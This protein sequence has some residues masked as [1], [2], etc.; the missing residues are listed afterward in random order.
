[1]AIETEFTL[2]LRRFDR[3]LESAEQRVNRSANNMNRSL[4][5]VGNSGSSG[6][7]Q[8]NAVA[9]RFDAIGDSADKAVTAIDSV[10]GAMGAASTGVTGLAGDLVNLIKNPASLW[11]A[12]VGMAVAAA[13]K[14]IDKFTLSASEMQERLKHFAEE[15]K[16][17]RREVEAAH[18]QERDYIDRL[19]ELSEAE[20][21]SQ[22]SKREAA[23]LIDQLN[24]KYGN[25]GITINSVTGEIEGLAD[26]ERKLSQKQFKERLNAMNNQRG[27]LSSQ[28]KSLAMLALG[29]TKLFGDI[30]GGLIANGDEKKA[31]KSFLETAPLEKQIEFFEKWRDSTGT[32]EGWETVQKIVELKTEELNIQREIEKMRSSGYATDEEIAEAEKQATEKSRH[33]QILRLRQERA[34]RQQQIAYDSASSSEKLSKRRS[35]LATEEAEFSA[36][37]NK[38]Y[39]L[40]QELQNLVNGTAPEDRDAAW[41]EKY[42]KIMSDMLDAELKMEQS[43]T[44]QLEIEEQ[45]AALEKEVA[46]AEAE[47]L[48]QAKKLHDNIVNETR[49]IAKQFQSKYGASTGDDK[50]MSRLRRAE[51]LKGEPLSITEIVNIGYLSQL[52]DEISRFRGL[53]FS[54]FS[55]PDTNDLTARGGFSTGVLETPADKINR[56]IQD[57]VWDVRSLLE[58]INHTL[59]EVNKI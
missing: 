58:S 35:D 55:V 9:E 13:V 47:R 16:K 22:D 32:I 54:Q 37:E 39:D 24:K 19:R 42:D 14:I 2:S 59:E 38:L 20:I 51:E 29:S 3:Q 26:A 10:S 56:E 45:I 43:K 12:A 33:A 52:E 23:M 30:F 6:G 57:I 49:D 53:D 34:A 50:R 41:Q 36:N 1:M 18:K 48:E 4:S 15:A 8:R 28:G 27:A 5:R 21:K 11:F 44:R 25:L 31:L 40:K 17:T 7:A 46:E